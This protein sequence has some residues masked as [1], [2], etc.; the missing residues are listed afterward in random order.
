MTKSHLFKLVKI[1]KN[2]LSITLSSLVVLLM[3][4]LVN[5]RPAI[6]GQIFGATYSILLILLLLIILIKRIKIKMNSIKLQF[7]SAA[8]VMLF[9]VIFQI[10]F[11]GYNSMLGSIA[12]LVYLF[13]G[14]SQ[15][16][17]IDHDSI[18]K[19]SKLLIGICVFLS[20]N[21]LVTY[22]IFILSSNLYITYVF[23]LATHTEYIYELKIM[24]PFSPVYN[25]TA[26]IASLKMPRAI[27]MMREPGL[28]QMIILISYW[29][30]DFYRFKYDLLVKSLLIFSLIVTFS[31]AG[32]ALFLVTMIWKIFNKSYKN[33]ILYL[34]VGVPILMILIYFV[35][36]SQSQF[37]ILEK[38][39]SK[40][41]L[42]RIG[43]S[44][45]SLELIS[46]NPLFGIG[47]HVEPNNIEI[48]INY[49]GTVAQLGIIGSLI[50]LTPSIYTWM[51][52]KDGPIQLIN[53]LF[54]IILTM[55]F[56]QPIYDKPL[57]YL[58]LSVLLILNIKSKKQPILSNYMIK[59][60][61]VP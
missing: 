50:F 24:F 18:K 42:S 56:A 60:S 23:N 7:I 51:K 54:V 29:L 2:I 61:D 20:I 10:F 17:I 16:V 44:I 13:I 35:I 48:G 1:N 59:P 30:Q 25:G 57:T 6:V 3:L 53:I 55:L 46:Q 45:T 31:T 34:F 58:F 32:Y 28:Y 27:G 22:A 4:F 38:F 33:R 43:A 19:F 9:Y 26:N 47:F 36:F 12:T 11:V 14:F 5:L 21:Y 40:S 39:E 8:I 49:L 37:G 15:I 41:G 52:I